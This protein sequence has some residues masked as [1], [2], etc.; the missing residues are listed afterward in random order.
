MND[1]YSQWGISESA[2]HATWQIA[3]DVQTWENRFE[4]AKNSLVFR[5]MISVMLYILPVQNHDSDLLNCR[6]WMHL[7][8]TIVTLVP[9]S[10]HCEKRSLFWFGRPPIQTY[11]RLNHF[12]WTY[13]TLELGISRLLPWAPDAIALALIRVWTVAPV[14]NHMNA[15]VS[16]FIAKCPSLLFVSLQT[17]GH[18]YNRI[19]TFVRVT[20]ASV[21]TEHVADEKNICFDLF[22]FTFVVQFCSIAKVLWVGS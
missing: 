1:H 2:R 19:C 9:S 20:T 14:L 16:P 18:L 13:Y 8:P 22:A 12:F 6:I 3:P 10:C 21:Y 15:H 17:T 5:L 7:Q 11:L 4:T